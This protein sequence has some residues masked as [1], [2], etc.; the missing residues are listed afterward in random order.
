VIQGGALSVQKGRLAKDGDWVSDEDANAIKKSEAK[1]NHDVKAIEYFIK[2]KLDGRLARYKEWVHFGLTSQDVNN[3]AFPLMIREAYQA[4]LIPALKSVRQD[5]MEFAVKTQYLP[6]LA[7]TH[8]QP[9]SPTVLGKELMVFVERLDV[10]I[11]QLEA[12]TLKVKFGGATGNFNA[13]VVAFP[14]INWMEWADN[15]T[16]TYLGIKMYHYTTQIEH[17]DQLAA[18]CH[19]ICGSIRS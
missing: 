6:M 12:V 14:E 7:H 2:D 18:L 9:A 8:G 16:S 10:Q 19:A 13:H 5:I 3:S 11:D 1:I 15:F 17:Y 4:Q